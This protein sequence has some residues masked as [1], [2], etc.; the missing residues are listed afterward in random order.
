M[1][2]DIDVHVKLPRT[3]TF[4]PDREWLHLL[5][6]PVSKL[7]DI[8]LSAPPYMWLRFATYTILGAQGRLSTSP[9]ALHEPDYDDL[10]LPLQSRTFYYHFENDSEQAR[11]F[12]LDPELMNPRSSITQSTNRTSDFKQGVLAR[13]A[14]RCVVTGAART[15][16]AHLIAHGDQVPNFAIRPGNVTFLMDETPPIFDDDHPQYLTHSLV[17]NAVNMPFMAE[18]PGHRLTTP[19]NRTQW[20]PTS[21]FDIVYAGVVWSHFGVKELIPQLRSYHPDSKT[22]RERQKEHLDH[23]ASVRKEARAESRQQR[24]DRRGGSEAAD[25]VGGTE[26]A[27]DEWEHQLDDK[28]PTD[29]VCFLPYMAMSPGSREAA[30]RAAKD[31]RDKKLHDFVCGWS[32]GV[33]GSNGL[34]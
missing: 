11:L 19:E 4:D 20:P 26:D 24:A 27:S 22:A 32:A 17:P 25:S 34:Q 3:V 21:L 8:T 5:R 18:L 1:A 10:V 31:A 30:L 29:I 23:E 16:A 12:V 28:D 6:C 2:A 15:Q 13:D 14:R 9:V 33:V 7:A